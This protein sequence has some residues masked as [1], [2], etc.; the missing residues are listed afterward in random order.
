MTRA[1]WASLALLAV[2][3]VPALAQGLASRV[4]GVEEGRVLITYPSRPGVEFCDHGIH[5]RD[6]RGGS[7]WNGGHD[8]AS[9]REGPARVELEVRDGRVRG[10]RVL[11][12]HMEPT[13]GAVDLGVVPAPDVARYFLSL[14]RTAPERAAKDAVFAAVLAD[15]DSTP[16]RR[17]LLAL[18]RDHTVGEHVRERALFWL[19]QEAAEEVTKGIADVAS[20]EEESQ[21]VRNA[22]IF[23]LSQRPS[24]EGVPMLMSLART[25][26]QAATRRSAMFWLAQSDDP[27]V[28]DFFERILLGS[29][30]G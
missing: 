6:L 24:D 9:C 12:A 23:A 26:R 18:A 19:G 22:A 15:A 27:R 2:L 25:A 11:R 4:E 14:A 30:G 29:G 28:P 8:D 20:D 16:F 17:T 10:V 1:R 7:V 3:P 21:G 5:M 13:R